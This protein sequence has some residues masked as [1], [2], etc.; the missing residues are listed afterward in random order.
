MHFYYF[1]ALARALLLPP[2]GLLLLALLGTVLILL[3]RQRI[4]QIC[5]CAGLGLLLFPVSA[6][7]FR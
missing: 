5:L 1:K 2:L 7:G 3:K 6:G 4:G